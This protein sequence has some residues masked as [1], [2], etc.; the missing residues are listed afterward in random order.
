MKK[1]LSQPLDEPVWDLPFE[2]MDVGDS[3]FIP[4][5][6][7]AYMTYVIDTRAKKAGYKVKVFTVTEK[8]ILGVRAWRVS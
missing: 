6:K 8:G 4:T 3:F 7:P 1:S 2:G 5:M